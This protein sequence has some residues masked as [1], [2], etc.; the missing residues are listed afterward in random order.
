MNQWENRHRKCSSRDS[1]WLPNETQFLLQLHPC[2]SPF[3]GMTAPF[4]LL[5]LNPDLAMISEEV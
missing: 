3:L 1:G 4:W 2:H 5:L